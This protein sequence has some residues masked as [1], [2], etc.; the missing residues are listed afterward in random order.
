MVVGDGKNFVSA[1]LVPEFESLNEWC[2]EQNL[3]F[4]FVSETVNSA[5]VVQMYDDIISE[6]N[7]SLPRFEQIKKFKLLEAPWSIEKK[8]LTQHRAVHK[9]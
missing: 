7:Q 4:D 5:D 9:R 2:K 8:E 1:L 6:V 3:H